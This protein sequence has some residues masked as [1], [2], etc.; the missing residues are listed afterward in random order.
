[1]YRKLSLMSK[2]GTFRSAAHLDEY[3]DTHKLARRR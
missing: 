2:G 1:V 3:I